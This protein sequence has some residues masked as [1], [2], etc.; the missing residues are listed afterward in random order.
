M[1]ADVAGVGGAVAGVGAGAVGVGAG[2]VG[3]VVVGV[4]AAL[5]AEKDVELLVET[6]VGTVE[7]SPR[8]AGA[9]LGEEPHPARPSTSRAVALI[10]EG[11]LKCRRQLY[12][13]R[14]ARVI[15]VAIPPDTRDQYPRQTYST[16]KTQD[17][18][19]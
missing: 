16:Q 1:G 7:G 2:V 19:W 15:E 9:E 10:A 8:A 3:V 18:A 14:T 12:R 6:A 4:V 5:V 13:P 17:C 11:N